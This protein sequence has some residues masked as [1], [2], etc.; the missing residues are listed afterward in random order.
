MR[1]LCLVRNGCTWKVVREYWENPDKDHPFARMIRYEECTH[2][3]DTR[4]T[5]TTPHRP[6]TLLTRPVDQ[7]LLHPDDMVTE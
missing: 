6:D 3:K 5:V 2:C 4:A 1:L 7:L